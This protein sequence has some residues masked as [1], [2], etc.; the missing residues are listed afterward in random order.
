MVA[1]DSRLR[2]T[3]QSRRRRDHAGESDPRSV[4][5]VGAVPAQMAEAA[6]FNVDHGAQ[7]IDINMGCPAKKVCNSHAGSALLGDETLVARI[8]A[9]VTAA[10][11]VPVTLKIRTGVAPERKN[12]VNIAQIAVDNGIAAI[13][14][15]G[16]TRACAF[17]GSAE[18]DTVAAIKAAVGIP[19][20]ANGDVRTPQDAQAI[21][22]RSQADGLMIGRA[23][24]GNPWIF[25]EI[26]HFLR[27][28]KALDP[29]SA[30]EVG[31]TLDEHLH[32]LHAFYG[33][34]LGVRVA[35]KHLSWYCKGRPGAAAFWQRI[36]RVECAT[37]QLRLVEDYFDAL[38][39][40]SRP[41]ERAA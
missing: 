10:V 37:T 29:P 40:S 19:V 36:N 22:C 27:T 23:A 31:S 41:W 20:I 21:L 6:R 35:R 32:A 13:A 7:I 3:A 17:R 30:S 5:I 15:H 38:A 28:G 34:Y 1:S 39:Q 14:V 16:R 9:A 24:Q 8:L 2:D 33:P 26:D 25:R 4:Q 12:G 11:D 18:H